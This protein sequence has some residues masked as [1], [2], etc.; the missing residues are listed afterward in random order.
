MIH[1]R[2]MWQSKLP[3]HL[4]IK[5]EIS[6]DEFGMKMKIGIRW[7]WDRKYALLRGIIYKRHEKD[8]N[9]E[10]NSYSL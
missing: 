5:E 3:S 10:L 8:K 4:V 7:I 1:R 9:T 2:D 6:I